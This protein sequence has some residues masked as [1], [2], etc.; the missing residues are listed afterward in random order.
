[1]IKNGETIDRYKIIELIKQGGM[2][3]VYKVKDLKLNT[4]WAMKEI[5]INGND[6]TVGLIETGIIKNARHPS[7]PRIVDIVRTDDSYC[8]LMDY[9]EG[10]NLEDYSKKAGG[11]SEDETVYIGKKILEVLDYLHNG[12][13]KIIYR[14][15]KPSNVMITPDKEIKLIDFGISRAEDEEI[16][17]GYGSRNFASSEQLLG[18]STDERSDI[19]SLGATLKF[20]MKNEPSIGFGIFLNKCTSNNPNERYQSA[21]EALEALDDSKK[22]TAQ[23]IIEMKRLIQKNIFCFI[24]FFL[25]LS[26]IFLSEYYKK[27]INRERYELLVKGAIESYDSNERIKYLKILIEREPTEEWYMKLFDEIKRDYEFSDEEAKEIEDMIKRDSNRLKENKAYIAVTEELG[28]M[29]VFYYGS[30]EN[31]YEKYLRASNWFDENVKN[32]GDA[33]TYFETT[34]FLSNIQSMILEGRDAGM[35]KQYFYGLKKLL[36]E[37]KDEEPTVESKILTLAAD[38]VIAYGSDFLREGITVKEMNEMLDSIEK[39]TSIEEDQGKELENAKIM[40]KER[41]EKAREELSY[42]ETNFK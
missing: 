5:S 20:V 39:Y 16:Y 11:L 13:Q 24:M 34:R 26:G 9:I 6:E 23:K 7:L 19:Y 10:M 15:L 29:Y 1:M 4:I 41:I 25:S 32:G 30:E 33:K 14:D 3:R 31:E 27:K 8:L 38:S 28:R 36:Q 17:M 37:L 42:I 40:L 12:Q 22:I 2:S 21:K 18:K 35:Y